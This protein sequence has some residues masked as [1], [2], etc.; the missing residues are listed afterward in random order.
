MKGKK[1][2]LKSKFTDG[3]LKS[4]KIW[5]KENPLEKD[6]EIWGKHGDGFGIRIRKKTGTI[7]FFYRY[8][9]PVKNGKRRYLSLGIYSEIFSLADANK[10]HNDALNLVLAGKDPMAPPPEPTPELTMSVE[11]SVA[12]LKDK[13]IDHVKTHLVPRSVKHHRER[14]AKYI[15]PIWGD[16]PARSIDRT[17]AIMLIE[18]MVKTKCGAARNVLLT[19]RAMFEYAL[20]RKHVDANP[21]FKISKAVPQAKPKKGQRNLSVEEIRLLWKELTYGYGSSEV[22][23]ILK[24]I[25]LLG[26][27]P[28]EVSSMRYEHIR[29]DWWVIPMEETKNGRNPNIDDQYKFDQWV[30][31]PPLAKEL[32][33][34]GT[35]YVFTPRGKPITEIAL[36][37]HVRRKVVMKDGN[38]VKL[39]FYG[40]QPWTPH[41]LRRTMTTQQ[42][43]LLTTSRDVLEAIL[44][45]VIPGVLGVYLQARYGT[46]KQQAG[47][48]WEKKLLE[49]VTP[50][51]S[52]ASEASCLRDRRRILTNY[53]IKVVWEGLSALSSEYSS[54]ALKLILITG[55]EVGKCAAFHRDEIVSDA[56]GAWWQIEGGNKIFLTPTARDLVGDPEGYAFAPRGDH[57]NIATLSYH[58]LKNNCFGL[59]K[60]TAETF[61]YTVASKLCELGAPNGILDAIEQGTPTNCWELRHW[62]ERWEKHLLGMIAE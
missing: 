5:V 42:A 35:G 12:D 55:Q 61:R 25:L 36:S 33:G 54:R 49:I 29:G 58:I 22:R 27:R 8:H 21:F 47:L 59:P 37:G 26:Q 10:K 30:Y 28:G 4:M 45:H 9:F 16:R 56:T 15:I 24:L 34:T 14:L 3:Y 50:P 32:I 43:E 19:A 44:G 53:E 6:E 57:I 41:D 11:L 20:E 51:E 13:Y 1:P 23:R 62:L 48:M 40:F 52:Q 18:E 17:E 46:Q 2:T 7:T 38:I 31:L 60:C 39:P